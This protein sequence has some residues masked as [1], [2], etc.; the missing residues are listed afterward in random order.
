MGSSALFV[1]GG[2]AILLASGQELPPLGFFEAIT[3]LVTWGL[4]IYALILL[5]SRSANAWFRAVKRQRD[6]G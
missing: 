5:F 2:Y 4:S 6:G 3:N 1:A